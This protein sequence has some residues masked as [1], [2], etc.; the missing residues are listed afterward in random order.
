MPWKNS[1]SQSLSPSSS[2]DRVLVI[3]LDGVGVGELPDAEEYGDK[4]SNTLGNL[5]RAVGGL[6]LPHL[7]RMG[8]GNITQIE[9]MAPQQS[10]QANFGK[11]RE[12]TG[13]RFHLR[14]LGADGANLKEAISHLSPWFSP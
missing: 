12:S 14:P 8:L 7:E 2:I 6:N 4:G 9:G 10:P 5:A 3:V 13:E 1:P 11:L